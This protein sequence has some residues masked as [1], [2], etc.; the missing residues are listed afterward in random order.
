MLIPPSLRRAAIEL[1]DAYTHTPL[2]GVN[3]CAG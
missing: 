1:Y 3:S 2:P